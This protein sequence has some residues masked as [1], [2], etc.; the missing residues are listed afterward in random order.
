MSTVS[1]KPNGILLTPDG[2]TLYLAD[3]GGALIYRYDVL[4]PGRL[5]NETRWIELGAGPDGM[6]LD[7]HGNLHV[8]CGGPGVK[9][10]SPQGKAL[11]VIE[12]PY[13]SN[14]LRRF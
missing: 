4:G 7:E 10:Y 12:V 3:N 8:A 6:T 1:K 5:T 9:V 14:R 11:G 13:A 2:K